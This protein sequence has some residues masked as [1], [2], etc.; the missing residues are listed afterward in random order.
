[1]YKRE[2]FDHKGHIL[3]WTLLMTADPLRKCPKNAKFY[4][5]VQDDLFFVSLDMNECY[6]V[7]NLKTNLI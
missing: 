5:L 1:M 6:D 2:T 7:K 4:T 3:L